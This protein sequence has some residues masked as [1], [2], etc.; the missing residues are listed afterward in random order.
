MDRREFLRLAGAQGAALASVGWVGPSGA[1]V[2]PRRSAPEIVVIGAGA[3]GGWTALHLRRLG[4]EV[5]L[6]DLY[7]P[8]NS[9]ATSAD[10]TRGIRTGYADNEL[11]SRWAKLAIERWKAWDA[12]WGSR[13][14]TTTG[15]LCMRGSWEGFLSLTTATWDRIGVRYERLSVDEASYRFPQMKLDGFEVGVYEPDA[16]VGR[17][18][19]ATITVAD[20]FQRLGGEVLVGKATPGAVRA[21]RLEDVVLEPG[22]RLSAQTF[23][24][25][26]GPWFPKLMPALM[27]DKIRIPMGN[28][29]YF[30]APP[31]ALRFSA[32]TCPSYN[33][34]GVTGWPILDHDSRGF[35]VRTGGRPGDDPDTSV[36]WIPEELHESARKVL[37]D[38]FPALADAPIL[39][40][41][42]CHY[43]I[44]STQNFIIDRHPEYENV[45]IAGGGS[46]EGFKFG[47]VLGEYIADRVTGRNVDQTLASEF[48][49]G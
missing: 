32:P 7:G 48:R 14:F 20:Q 22:G 25:A 31:G 12:E 35:R 38:R 43:E 36:R 2:P 34:P 8:G 9:R 41:R 44:S 45:W 18:R 47:P 49:L 11:W 5:T 29:F 17:A 39:E 16:G 15:D 27:A 19:Y 42:S 30:G 3:F 1:T 40:T 23:V 13:M 26:V 4:H 28:V 6:V 10:E 37:A 33:F 46:A 24:F 21:G